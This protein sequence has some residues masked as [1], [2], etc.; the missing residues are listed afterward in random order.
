MDTLDLNLSPYMKAPEQQ[1]NPYPT[2]TKNSGSASLSSTLASSSE[3][4]LL[5]ET[6]KATKK[7]KTNKRRKLNKSRRRKIKR[8]PNKKKM[9]T[10]QV[11]N[12]KIFH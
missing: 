4:D 6:R 10:K 12:H 3:N 11:G 2:L 5:S 8:R 7:R 9:A 1:Y